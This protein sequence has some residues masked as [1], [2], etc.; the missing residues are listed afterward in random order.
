MCGHG[1]L[2]RTA[3][4]ACRAA[5]DSGC[6]TEDLHLDLV[7]HG[8]RR[9][10]GLRGGAGE[11]AP[12]LVTPPPLLADVELL[13]AAAG[14]AS[15]SSVRHP[16]D[17]VASDERRLAPRPPNGQAPKSWERLALRSDP[18]RRRQ[19]SDRW[20]AWPSSSS[21]PRGGGS[22]ATTLPSASSLSACGFRR[23]GLPVASRAEL[24][25]RRIGAAG[26]GHLGGG[27]LPASD[28]RTRGSRR[29]SPP[30]QRPS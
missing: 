4:G 17:D 2:Q 8:P 7:L 25:D 20:H 14:T 19:R 12:A 5:R 24:A 9:I 15:R 29:R 23:R 22:S 13:A 26:A 10:R 11:P 3:W 18:L 27:D 1:T 6:V 30:G 21:T 16:P 28:T